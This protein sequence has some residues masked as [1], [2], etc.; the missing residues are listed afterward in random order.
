MKEE[1]EY[2]LKVIP[3]K[4]EKRKKEIEKEIKILL[5]LRSHKNIIYL[6]DHFSSSKNVHGLLF[7]M[8]EMNLFHYLKSSPRGFISEKKSKIIFKQILDAVNFCHLNLIIHN[9]LK[10]ENVCI[11][12]KTLETKLIDFGFASIFDNEE[13][14]ENMNSNKGTPFFSAPVKHNFQ[15]KSKFNFKFLFFYN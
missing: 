10:L 2:C 6:Q 7:G 11:N 1:K 9:D 3:F 15:N 14:I 8:M 5:V 13:K 12:P 4:N